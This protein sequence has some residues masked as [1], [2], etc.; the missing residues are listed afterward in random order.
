M[1]SYLSHADPKIFRNGLAA[2]AVKKA[3]VYRFQEATVPARL[4][5]CGDGAGDHGNRA[6]GHEP[7]GGQLAGRWDHITLW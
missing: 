4:Q 3:I 6:G 7:N 1:G 5:G 2:A